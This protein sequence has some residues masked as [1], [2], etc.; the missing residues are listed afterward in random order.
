MVMLPK[1]ER[2]RQIKNYISISLRNI[3]AEILKEVL[4]RDYNNTSKNY[5][6]LNWI[7]AKD[8][9]TIQC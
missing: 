7:Y 1:S 5:S 6:L 8:T 2:K 9:R 4:A 3:G